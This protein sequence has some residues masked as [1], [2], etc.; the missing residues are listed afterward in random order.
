MTWFL[1]LFCGYIAGHMIGHLWGF[2][3]GFNL[4]R[5]AQRCGKATA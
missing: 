3:N 1:W 4:G 2:Y 5:R